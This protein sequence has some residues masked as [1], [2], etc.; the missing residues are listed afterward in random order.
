MHFFEQR[1]E[2][3]TQKKVARRRSRRRSEIETMENLYESYQTDRSMAYNPMENS[4]Q[5]IRKTKK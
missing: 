5:R 3:Y 1:A 4:H 2:G